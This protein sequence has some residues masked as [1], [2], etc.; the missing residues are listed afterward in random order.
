MN[1]GKAICFGII[2]WVLMFVIVSVFIAYNFYKIT[3][4]QLILAVIAGLISF[5]LAKKIKPNKTILALI[6]GLI[7]VVTGVILDAFITMRFNS[8][9]FSSWSLWLGYGLVFLAPLLTVKRRSKI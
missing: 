5:L 8:E 1:L 4:V 7:W 6:Y 9:I 2:I 3:L